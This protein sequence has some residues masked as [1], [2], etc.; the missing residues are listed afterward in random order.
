[1]KRAIK[2]SKWIHLF[3]NIHIDILAGRQNIVIFFVCFINENKLTTTT[4]EIELSQEILWYGSLRLVRQFLCIFDVVFNIEN[5]IH[6]VTVH[7]FIVV[8]WLPRHKSKLAFRTYSSISSG[9]NF[10]LQIYFP[11]FYP[12]ELVY[13]FMARELAPNIDSFSR[14]LALIG[15][16]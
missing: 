15:L 12:G 11:F 14:Y 9:I 2:R 3:V 10:F 8:I 16:Y 6:D 1:M 7:F 13:Y 4:V 5:L